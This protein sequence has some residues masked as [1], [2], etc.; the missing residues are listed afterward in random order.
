[1]NIQSLPQ[2]SLENYQTENVP[3]RF[4]RHERHPACRYCLRCLYSFGHRL[5]ML[6]DPPTS[7]VKTGDQ[8]V[9]GLLAAAVSVVVYGYFGGLMHLFIGL[10]VGNLYQVWTRGANFRGRCHATAFDTI[11]PITINHK[12]I[13]GIA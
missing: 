6:T 8:I 4:P 10:F 13:I 12:S 5:F 2:L 7:P 1:M 9:F 3:L 11:H